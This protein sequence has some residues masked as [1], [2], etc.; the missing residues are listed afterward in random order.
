MRQSPA[1]VGGNANRLS[2]C[3]QRGKES[4][5]EAAGRRLTPR[6]A[7][8]IMDLGLEGNTGP[9]M[10]E[11]MAPADMT[12]ED[13]T[14]KDWDAQF[15][16]QAAWTRATRAFLYRRA[17][18]LR[19]ERVLDVGCGT[20]VITEELAARTRGRVV[21]VDLD[22]EMVAYAQQRG[23]QA[24]YQAGDAHDLVFADGWFDLV[25]CHFVLMW[26]RDPARVAQEMVRV[27]R[28]GGAVLVCA[29]P[30]YGGRIDHPDLPMGHLQSRSLRREGADPWLGRQLRGL[31]ALPGVRHTDVGVI[32]GLWDLATL[33]AQFDDEWALW[34]RS[35]AGLVPAGELADLQEADLTAIESGERMVFMPVFYA[36]VRV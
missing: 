5:K 14:P 8:A 3:H 32:P 35:L 26:C 6:A 21:G 19:A 17:N 22:P 11:G 12:I 9:K 25:A 30:D 27:T 29:E 1:E 13:M 23:G 7:T 33:R 15:A 28:P 36:L 34:E 2:G 16:R 10:R 31:F 24:E 4:S 18:L 20:G